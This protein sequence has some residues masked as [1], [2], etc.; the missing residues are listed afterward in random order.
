M[1]KSGKSS[2]ANKLH[3]AHEQHKGDETRVSGGGELP[4]G[5]EHGIAR[6]ALCKIG[7]FKKGNNIGEPY[8]MA[9]GVVCEPKEHTITEGTKKRV[10]KVAGLRTGIGP[11]P[12]CDTKSQAGEVTTLAD[13]WDR[14]LNHLR[15]LDVDTKTIT[16]EQVVTEGGKDGYSSGPVLQ[17]LEKAKPYFGF[18]TWKGKATEQ[19]PDPRV[20]HQW[21]PTCEYDPE[22]SSG[23]AD[24]T[25]APFESEVEESGPEIEDEAGTEEVVDYLE[26]GSV[27][28]AGKPKAK[29]EAAQQALTDRAQEL[30]VE[31]YEDMPTWTEVAEA[32]V[33]AEGE[34]EDGSVDGDEEEEEFFEEEWAPT[35]GETCFAK[36]P[37]AKEPVEVEIKAINGEKADVL[38]KDTNR[39]TKNVPFANLSVDGNF[40]A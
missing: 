22:A 40:A 5:I 11:I 18:R 20:N 10:V 31:G 37:R 34:P 23:V 36:M 8:F 3:Q 4:E 15:L 30:S 25:E 13:H 6:L 38:R 16:G 7:V 19:Y 32:I 39:T 33:A 1:A 27:A 9:Q 2:F 29:A 26:L 17:L 14:V 35:V 24:E 28:D 12:L 21:G